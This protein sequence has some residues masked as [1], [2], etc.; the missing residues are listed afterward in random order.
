ME[1]DKICGIILGHSLG[2]ALGSPHEFYPHGTYTGKLEF[3][4]SKYNQNY[5]LRKGVIGQVSDD[6]EVSLAL[7][8]VLISGYTKEKAV[9]EYMNWANNR[10]CPDCQGNA[11][12]IGHNLRNLFVIPKQSKPS[13]QLYNSRYK[14]IYNTPEKR[15]NSQSNGA[16]MRS[17]PFAFISS[18]ER[19]TLLETDIKLT[20]PSQIALNASQVYVE[21]IRMTIGGKTKQE[22]KSVCKELIYV[23]ILMEVYEKACSNQF[24]DITINPGHLI[25]AFYCTFWGLF[26]FE[27]YKSAID[28]IICLGSTENPKSKLCDPKQKGSVKVGDTD[29]NAAIAGALLGGYYGILSMCSDSITKNNLRILITSNPNQ[30]KLP[31]PLKYIPYYTELP[32][33]FF[34]AYKL[35]YTI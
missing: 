5:G 13:L 30:G 28:A 9:L 33:I 20:N 6:T 31:R 3:I 4:L 25:N 21:A 27:D 15:E 34:Q 10:D 24:M 7:L 1:F 19:Q 22:I 32:Y 23:P 26:N 16:L 11:P 29:T 18:P 17:Y 35:Y 12:N 8:R 2:D 14:K